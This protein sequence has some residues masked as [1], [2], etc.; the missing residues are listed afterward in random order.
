M[1]RRIQLVMLAMGC[2]VLTACT[3]LVGDHGVIHD[4]TNQY[5]ESRNGRALEV[6]RNLSRAKISDYYMIPS[7]RR[8][9]NGVTPLPPGSLVSQIAQTDL[10]GRH[11]LPSDAVTLV[12]KKGAE[13]Y[14]LIDEKSD[15]ALLNVASGAHK[16]NMPVL[17]VDRKQHTVTV[18]DIYQTFDV[19]TEHTPTFNL[20]LVPEQKKTKVLIRDQ[21]NKVIN[22]NTAKRI[23]AE[24]EDGLHGKRKSGS[25]TGWIRNKLS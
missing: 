1:I 9:T 3:D 21:K 15:D 24:L 4:R 8:Q 17:S 18:M 23:L 16:R 11:A 6:P 13:P 22:V 19:V 20:T 10:R 12:E 14:M 7:A 25:L 5:L 2:T